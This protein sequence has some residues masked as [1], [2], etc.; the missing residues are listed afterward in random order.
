MG[1]DRKKDFTSRIS[2]QPM[3]VLSVIT[4][5]TISF[6]DLQTRARAQKD[7]RSPFMELYRPDPGRGPNEGKVVFTWNVSGENLCDRPIALY[8]R[9]KANGAWGL[10]AGGLKNTGEYAWRLPAGVPSKVFLRLQV[11]DKD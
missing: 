11:N 7:D 8:Y 9:E 3:F 5:L 6:L 4:C 1:L 2:L 10:I